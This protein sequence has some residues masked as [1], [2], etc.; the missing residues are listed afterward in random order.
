MWIFRWFYLYDTKSNIVI[1]TR[2][3]V[4]HRLKKCLMRLFIS[5][6]RLFF[7]LCLHY[8]SSFAPKISNF[9]FECFLTKNYFHFRYRH[10]CHL[11]TSHFIH[12]VF[13][14]FILH[15]V[16]IGARPHIVLQSCSKI[17]QTHHFQHIHNCAVTIFGAYVF[18]GQR[19]ATARCQWHLG[20]ISS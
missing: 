10:R 12:S 6:K 20:S 3:F 4:Y 9:R 19:S 17:F 8:V 15:T 7:R 16:F 13:T 18:V 2:V 1:W 11:S 14:V 5:L